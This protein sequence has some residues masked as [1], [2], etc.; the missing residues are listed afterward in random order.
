VAPE[1][2]K[3]GQWLI[4]VSPLLA[5]LQHHSFSYLLIPHAVIII[6]GKFGRLGRR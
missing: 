6:I 1:G 3:A 4:N 2:E 5:T